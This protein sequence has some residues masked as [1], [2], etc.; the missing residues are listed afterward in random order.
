MSTLQKGSCITPQHLLQILQQVTIKGDRV[1]NN[2]HDIVCIVRILGGIDQVLANYLS[3]SHGLAL[4]PSQI[5]KLHQLITLPPTF[6]NRNNPKSKTEIQL[7]NGTTED[8]YSFCYEFTDS[9]SYLSYIFGIDIARKIS[10]LLDSSIVAVFHTVCVLFCVVLSYIC[11]MD[12]IIYICFIVL[13]SLC[14]ISWIIFVSLWMLNLN[15]SAFKLIVQTFE[16]SFKLVYAFVHAIFC[17]IYWDKIYK[18]NLF[19]IIAMNFKVIGTILWVSSFDGANMGRFSKTLFTSIFAF[20]LTVI[21]IQYSLYKLDGSSIVQYEIIINNFAI[22]VTGMIAGSSRIL[23]I[24]LWKQAILTFFSKNKCVLIRYRPYVVWN[25]NDDDTTSDTNVEVIPI[26]TQLSD[27]MS[28]DGVEI[29]A[30]DMK[31]IMIEREL[32]SSFL[33]EQDS[34]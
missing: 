5:S 13:L 2:P 6:D 18:L 30:T 24:F 3:T 28:D 11:Q 29:N 1:I 8:P 7:T 26:E 9:N 4:T 16:F 14:S 22:S 15:I 17:G 12:E 25:T 10:K 19:I 21:S 27:T 32:S 34:D 23:A 20:I 33:N 31:M